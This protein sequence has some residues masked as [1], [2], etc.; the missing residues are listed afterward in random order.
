[1]A[2][3]QFWDS[4]YAFAVWENTLITLP[5]SR[6]TCAAALA[7]VNEPLLLLVVIKRFSVQVC[8]SCSEAGK[9]LR[10]VAPFGKV[11]GIKQEKI[12]MEQFCVWNKYI[13]SQRSLGCISDKDCQVRWIWIIQQ[14]CS[15][16]RIISCEGNDLFELSAGSIISSLCPGTWQMSMLCINTKC[17]STKKIIKSQPLEKILRR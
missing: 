17:T 6:R 10:N 16:L 12:V 14:I 2:Q 15:A 7:R 11:K 1:M 8:S 5:L 13:S 9:M 4:A 3:I